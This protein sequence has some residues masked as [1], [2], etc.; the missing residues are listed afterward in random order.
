MRNRSGRSESGQQGARSARSGTCPQQKLCF[1]D[2]SAARGSRS[3][4]QDGA[5]P[6]VFKIEP[7]P[8]EEGD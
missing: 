7:I 6:V 3:P 4:V 8:T 5:R 2:E 1:C